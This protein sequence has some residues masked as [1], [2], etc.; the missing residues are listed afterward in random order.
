MT[1]FM[2]KLL[3]AVVLLTLAF[4]SLAVNA[5]QN[6][7][8]PASGLLL[9]QGGAL[10]D[11]GQYKKAAGFYTQIGRNDTNYVRGLYGASLCYSADSQFNKSLE[12]IKLALSIDMEP[13]KRPELLTHYGLALD[14]LGQTDKAIEVFDSAI[15]KYPAYS[16]LYLNKGTV[17]IRKKQYADAEAVFKQL[18]LIDPYS[19]SSHFKLGVCALNQGKLVQ[20]YLSFVAYLLLSPEGRYHTNCISLL[21]SISNNKDEIQHYV[22]NRQEE[23]QDNYKELEQILQSKIALDKNYKSLIQLDDPISRQIQVLFEKIQYQESDKEFWMQYYVPYFKSVFTSGQFETFIYHC[24]STVNLPVIQD[25]LKKNKKERTAMTDAAETYFNGIRETRELNYTRRNSDEGL[26]WSFYNGS[27][28]GYG[29]TLKKGDKETGP[30]E[31][32]YS[33]GNIKGK[34]SY[35]EQGG[36]EGP[37]TY[38]YYDGKIKGKEL[39]GNG[40]QEGEETYY[41]NNGQVA[42]HSFYKNGNAEGESRTY[43]W[44][45]TPR[46]ITHYHEGKEEGMKLSFYSNGDTSLLENYA[47]GTQEG[48]T[49]SWAVNGTLDGIASYHNGKL[50]GNYKKFYPNGQVSSEGKYKAGKLE[51]EWKSYY[52]GGQL[53]TDQF[54]ANDKA[55]GEYKEYAENGSL[56]GTYTARNGKINGEA[57]YMDDDGKV[58]S[59][60]QYSGDILQKARFLD[61]DGKVISESER[62]DKRLDLD[63]YHADG[64]LHLKAHYDE[65]GDIT[66][67][68]TF[69]FASGK[70]HETDEYEAGREQG[71]SIAYFEDGAKRSETQYADGQKDGYYRSYFVHGQLQ[72]QGWYS[73]DNLS[74]DWVVYND[75]G[76]L[77]DSASYIN[78]DLNGYKTSFMPNGRKEYELRYHLGWL[79]EYT[80]YDTM[81]K[82]LK[83]IPLP[84]GTGKV[85]L[86]YPNGQ[87]YM[88][89]EYKGSKLTGRN[90][91]HY[92][93]GKTMIS[94]NYV[95]GEL[96]GDYITFYYSGVV[97]AKGQYRHGE[98]TGSWNYYYPN[99]QLHTKEEY[100]YGKLTGKQF[101][102]FEDGKIASEANFKD[103]DKE[104]I[105]KEYAPD[106]TL[107]YQM[108]YQDGT[109]VGY[110]YAGKDSLVPEIP[111]PMKGGKIKAYFSN[112]KAAA[113][114]EYLDGFFNGQRKLY[115]P[116]GQL[117]RMVTYYNGVQEGPDLVYYPNGKLRKESNFSHDNLNGVYKEYNEKGMIREE[118]NYYDGSP[119]GTVKLYNEGGQLKETD[120]YYYGTLLSVKNESIH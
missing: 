120:L 93:D 18:L 108:R 26:R 66:G 47:G 72:E 59:I 36:K 33:A 84:S 15:L 1:V 19:Y 32:Y 70:L 97:N 5:Q 105:G 82:E 73:Q 91:L 25:F 35:N 64:T 27:L 102:Y 92:F 87:P 30:W 110:R 37:W 85:Q 28:S 9:Q 56:T 100:V 107:L 44:V 94:S 112:G 17:L 117:W 7:P 67:E 29:K 34:G 55:E 109:P 114:F 4:S 51:G 11:S 61:K 116:N 12:T 53:K 49:R 89:S 48:E 96:D 77:T 62:K 76:A 13:E 46:A 41:F 78:G 104:G 65:K 79:I 88:E 90:V 81:G 101:F 20:A 68:E 75:Q 98:K 23:P 115:F 80:Q 14:D 74:G 40:K 42:S 8:P 52:P 99:G 60:Y 3:T 86:I 69:Y 95:R 39:H 118:W 119:H 111:L 22:N 71:P 2:N 63:Q 50:D 24:F 57:R 103:D 16:L 83:R 54:Y 21:N 43:Y 106:G 45:G 113:E 38:F 58:Y 6:D 10:Y 31:Y